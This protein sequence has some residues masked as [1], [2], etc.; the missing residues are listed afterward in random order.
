MKKPAIPIDEAARISSLRALQILD[1]YPEDRFDRVTKLA[2]QIFDVDI[3]LISLVDSHRQ[4]FKSRQ[5]LDATETRRDISFCGHAILDDAVLYVEDAAE[6]ERFHDNPLVTEDPDIRFYAG[7][8]IKAPEGQRI[9]TLCLI[10][11]APRTLSNKELEIL[12]DLARMVE[13]EFVTLAQ[14][15]VDELTQLINRRGFFTVASHVLPLCER[16]GTV[17]ELLYFDLNNFTRIN[18]QH[19]HQVGDGVLV[20]FSRLLTRCFRSAD[21]IARIG[22]DE[23]VVLVTNTTNQAAPALERLA[24]LRT[25]LPPDTQ[26]HLNWGIGV[27]TFDAERHATVDALVED[28]LAAMIEDK[29]VASSGDSAA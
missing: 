3:C 5:G 9:G 25:A 20:A 2:K 12:D 22:G 28:A 1:S 11:R 21:V 14:S 6:D 10:D 23:F 24:E 19:G 7:R 17:A 27:A 4:W 13:E 26:S 29:T 8:P 18:E 15:S 16:L